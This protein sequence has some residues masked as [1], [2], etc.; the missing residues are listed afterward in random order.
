[1]ASVFNFEV[2][3]AD[4]LVRF[5]CP[6]HQRRIAETIKNLGI[7]VNDADSSAKKKCRFTSEDKNVAFSFD[8][9]VVAGNDIRE[10]AVF[11]ENTEYP[12]IVRGKGKE[13]AEISLAINDHL[14]SG[15]DSRSTIISSG[16]ELYGSL[17]FH[18][19]VGMTDLCF[20]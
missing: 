9:K 11:F 20:N 6:N 7:D 5:S 13:L 8:G 2:S 16:G 19:Q 10:D 1:M 18:N 12:L 4:L 15:D 14:R 3:N 17:N